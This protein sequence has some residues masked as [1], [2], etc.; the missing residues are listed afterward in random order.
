[1]DEFAY[2]PQYYVYPDGSQA[3]GFVGPH[4]VPEGAIEVF[5][6]P[7]RADQSWHFPGWGES[8]SLK[9]EQDAEWKIAE[10]MLI[11][12]QLQRIEEHEAG[13]DVLDLLPGDRKQWLA[14]RGEI[15]RYEAGERPK[16]PI[17]NK[18]E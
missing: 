8:P 2:T 3:G 13:I 9:A 15:R 14:Y 18:A 7:L 4:E 11:E 17:E 16:R 12:V 10:L 1:M 6:A 5:E